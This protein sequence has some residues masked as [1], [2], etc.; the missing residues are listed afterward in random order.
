M[1]SDNQFDMDYYY[2]HQVALRLESKGWALTPQ[3]H[4]TRV[5]CRYIKNDYEYQISLP[6]NMV[7]NRV[8][9]SGKI[10]GSVLHF[11]GYDNRPLFEFNLEWSESRKWNEFNQWVRT[12]FEIDIHDLT[13]NN[14]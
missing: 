2:F 10:Y 3:Q 6:W 8:Q 1:L 12:M 14:N 11:C 4:G 5:L 13:F 9:D 7:Y